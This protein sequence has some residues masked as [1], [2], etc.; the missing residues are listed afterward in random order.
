MAFG[1]KWLRPEI[2]QPI[3]WLHLLILAVV[4]LGLLQLAFGGNMFTLWTILV[5]VPFLAAG[6]IVAH[7]L[8]KLD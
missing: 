6:D 3:Y 8:L 4:S 1:I 7:T 2:D 5:S